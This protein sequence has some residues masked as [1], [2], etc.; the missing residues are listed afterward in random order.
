MLRHNLARA[1][2]HK[3][4]KV[5]SRVQLQRPVA[6]RVVQLA[7]QARHLRR[8]RVRVGAGGAGA[9]AMLSCLPCITTFASQLAY[10]RP[11]DWTGNQTPH[12]GGGVRDGPRRQALLLLPL[13]QAEGPPEGLVALHEAAGQAG[14]DLRRQRGERSASFVAGALATPTAADQR[15]N[16]PQGAKR[17]PA[18]ARWCCMRSSPRPSRLPRFA[19]RCGTRE[20]V[21][22]CLSPGRI[23]S[24]V[25]CSGAPRVERSQ[26][27]HRSHS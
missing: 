13:V 5:P 4:D 16:W 20:E 7:V 19:E 11:L 21:P 9:A 10:W 25:L 14:G 17:S 8:P 26:I 15:E 22:R 27:A 18:C 2:V 23:M 12:L 6:Q 24:C 3:D 1:A